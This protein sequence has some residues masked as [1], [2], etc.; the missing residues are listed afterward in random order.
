M[1]ETLQIRGRVRRVEPAPPAT[2]VAHFAAR[3]TVETDCSDVWHDLEAGGHGI[4]VVDTRSA[5]AFAE[6][7]VPGAVHLAHGA[8]DRASA[9]SV[10]PDGAVAV[11]Y[12][13][14]PHCNAA[15]QG[16]LRLAELGYPVKEMIGGFDYW[17]RDGYPVASGPA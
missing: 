4:V 8:I 12:C 15:T 2:A 3:L 6:A 10:I 14:G 1:S 13:W 5:E 9:S 11:T 17:R 16:A 7:R